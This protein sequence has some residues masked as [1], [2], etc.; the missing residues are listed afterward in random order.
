[1]LVGR[2][3]LEVRRPGS[4]CAGTSRA[5]RPARSASVRRSASIRCRRSRPHRGGGPSP[6]ASRSGPGRASRRRSSPATR[7]TEAMLPTPPHCAT[8]QPPGRRTAARFAN[9][10]SW[11]GTQWNVAVDRIASTVPSI[12]SGCPRSATTYSIRSP[13]GASRSRAA[14]IIDGEP[15]SATTRPRGRRFAS[16]S[17]TRPL[18]QPASR[19][20]SSPSSGS[21]SRTARPPA[22]LRVGDPVVGPGVPVARHRS[23]VVRRPVRRARRT[24]SAGA[25][26]P[27][28]RPYHDTNAPIASS[29]AQTSIARWK[30]SIDAWF[31][32][33][34]CAAVAPA[35]GGLSGWNAARTAGSPVSRPG[36][37][38]ERRVV[39]GADRD[40]D[41]GAEQRLADPRDRVVDGR[42]EPREAPR[43]RAHQRARQRRHDARDAEAEEQRVGQDVDDA[44]RPAGRSW[45][46]RR[47]PPSTAPN[48]PAA[49]RTRAA[50]APSG[51]GP[52]TRKRREPIRPATVPIRVDR[53]ASMIPTGMP[54]RP[55]PSA[56]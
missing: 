4:P 31:E 23:L 11:S 50:R 36:G 21:R 38:A 5:A 3:P 45:P 48:R 54:T 7:W 44:P 14:S 28:R 37:R 51:A 29:P 30:A 19:T 40:E 46:G 22:G 9:S 24:T 49:A 47:S 32:A 35:A 6:S 16:S 56:V 12:G 41:E 33:A 39:R 10:A 52:A 25:P 2:E 13:N 18:P 34:I 26:A 15:S 27:S 17:V 8:S 43:D 55:A 1:M 53:S 42:A 20:R